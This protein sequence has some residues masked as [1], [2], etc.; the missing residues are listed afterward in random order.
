MENKKGRYID[1]LTEE[2]YIHVTVDRE[3]EDVVFDYAGYSEHLILLISELI[4]MIAKDSGTTEREILIRA[5]TSLV[6]QTIGKEA[7]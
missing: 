7:V 4:R 1:L 2:T 5:M 6:E 3:I